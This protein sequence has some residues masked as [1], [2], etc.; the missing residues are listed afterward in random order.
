M[1]LGNNRQTEEENPPE[2]YVLVIHS[3]PEAVSV[4]FF[5]RLCTFRLR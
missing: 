5:R 3:T 1:E 4:K 2:P